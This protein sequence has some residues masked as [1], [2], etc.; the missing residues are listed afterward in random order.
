MKQ[1]E[2]TIPHLRGTLA[3]PKLST[4]SSSSTLKPKKTDVVKNW[5]AERDKLTKPMDKKP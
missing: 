4:A 3:S 5:Q 1:R 2:K